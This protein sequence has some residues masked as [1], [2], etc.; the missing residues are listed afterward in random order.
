MFDLTCD[1]AVCSKT[2][3]SYTHSVQATVELD[4]DAFIIELEDALVYSCIRQDEIVDSPFPFSKGMR[5]LMAA[6]CS[7]LC[8]AYVS[9]PGHSG[10]AHL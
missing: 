2:D 3:L 5:A 1:T 8:T 7:G 9:P 6:A 10:M 4:T